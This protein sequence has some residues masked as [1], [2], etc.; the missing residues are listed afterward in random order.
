MNCGETTLDGQGRQTA[1]VLAGCLSLAV[2]LWAE[3]A[4][5]W[6]QAERWRCINLAG[7]AVAERGDVL[8][9]RKTPAKINPMSRS[10]QPGDVARRRDDTWGGTAPT[11]N[12]LARGLGCLYV[13]RPEDCM[14]LLRHIEA[15][16]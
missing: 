11:F 6:T 13:E 9:F 7:E 1:M 4:K 2:P 3:R 10:E 14:Q 5:N 12:V 16:G 15:R 8:F